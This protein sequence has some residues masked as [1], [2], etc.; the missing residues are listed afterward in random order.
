[1]LNYFIFGCVHSRICIFYVFSGNVYWN[2]S[3]NVSIKHRVEDFT[4][5]GS[6]HSACYAHSGLLPCEFFS[7]KWFQT[8]VMFEALKL[9]GRTSS[10]LY[11]FVFSNKILPKRVY[12]F[13]LQCN[14]Q[15]GF[16]F[17]TNFE[18]VQFHMFKCNYFPTKQELGA[19][20]PSEE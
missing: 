15:S 13:G 2:I 16:S 1:M 8:S 19:L 20:M 9:S 3:E 6:V 10:N 12:I 18:I 4:T 7:Q 11:Y 5:F 17:H 14:A